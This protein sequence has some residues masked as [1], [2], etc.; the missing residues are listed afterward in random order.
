MEEIEDG[1]RTEEDESS[2]GYFLEESKSAIAQGFGEYS[3]E[4]VC[5]K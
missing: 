4:D 2:T 1:E 5:G 3:G